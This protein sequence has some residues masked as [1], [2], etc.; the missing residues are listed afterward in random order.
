[1]K[2]NPNICKGKPAGTVIGSSGQTHID[3]EVKAS[4][5]EIDCLKNKLKN[6]CGE[7]KNIIDSRIKQME[8]YRDGFK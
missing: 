7:C 6:G 1:M 5:I 4:N 2:A 8:V 3:T